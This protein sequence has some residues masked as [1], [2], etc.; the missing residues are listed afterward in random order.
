[1][2]PQHAG[3]AARVSCTCVLLHEAY[4]FRGGLFIQDE[5]IHK[6][7]DWNDIVELFAWEVHI[8]IFAGLSSSACVCVASVEMLV[9]SQTASKAA[10]NNTE[11]K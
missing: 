11:K 3:G 7:I 1:M 2:F 5:K 9:L 8:W 4:E 10:E 6:S